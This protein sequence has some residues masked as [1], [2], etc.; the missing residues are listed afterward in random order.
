MIVLERYESVFERQIEQKIAV[1]EYK[2]KKA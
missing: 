2:Q 1:V